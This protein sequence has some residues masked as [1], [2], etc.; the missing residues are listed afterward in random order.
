MCELLLECQSYE[1]GT[2]TAYRLDWIELVAFPG[3]IVSVRV[4]VQVCVCL[5]MCVYAYACGVCECVCVSLI[6]QS[7]CP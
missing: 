2:H 4:S 5:R 3:N 6:V 7:V 1:L